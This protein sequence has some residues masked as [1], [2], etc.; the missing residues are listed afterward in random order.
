ML[1]FMDPQYLPFQLMKNIK[2]SKKSTYKLKMVFKCE[3]HEVLLQKQ[4]MQLIQRNPNFNT[5]ML[6]FKDLQNLRF[7]LMKK[8]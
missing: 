8:I 2:W 3:N 7:L 1:Y 5:P 4:F 6:Y